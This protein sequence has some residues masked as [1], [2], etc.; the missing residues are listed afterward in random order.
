MIPR[1][2]EQAKAEAFRHF[3]RALRESRQAEREYMK[4]IRELEVQIE[5]AITKRTFTG[6]CRFEESQFPEGVSIAGF[7]RDAEVTRWDGERGAVVLR[8]TGFVYTSLM[9]VRRKLSEKLR[10]YCGCGGRVSLRYFE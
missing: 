10:L 8:A 2:V 3:G 7:L 6:W 1:S 5:R 9:M 4:R